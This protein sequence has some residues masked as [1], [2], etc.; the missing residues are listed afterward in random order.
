MNAIE[1]DSVILDFPI[2]TG[3]RYLKEQVTGRFKTEG[4]RTHL[5][6]LDKVNMQI[7]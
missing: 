6:A 4:R 3:A 2:K 1:L 7:Q 5:R